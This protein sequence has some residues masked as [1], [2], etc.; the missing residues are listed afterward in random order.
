MRF[1]TNTKPIPQNQKLKRGAGKTLYLS[2][3]YRDTWN[4]IYMEFNS[5]AIKNQWKIFDPTTPLEV[6]IEFDYNRYDVDS[7]I[8]SVLDILEGI[9]YH[10]D[11]QVLKV[12]SEKYKSSMPRLIVT[13]KK[14]E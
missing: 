11:K 12:T 9:A 14:Y 5:Q 4:A 6:N 1:T 2:P 8:K 7:L 10:N 3:I 13:V